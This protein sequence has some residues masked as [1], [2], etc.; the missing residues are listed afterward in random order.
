MDPATQTPDL[1][2]AGLPPEQG[3]DSLMQALQAVSGSVPTE[4]I[5]QLM[6][7]PSLGQRIAQAAAGGVAFMRGQPNPVTPILQQQQEQNI[8]ILNILQKMQ[9][10]QDLN[11][12]R[13]DEMRHRRALE[14]QNKAVLEN[15]KLNQQRQANL[16][17]FNVLKGLMDDAR[18]PPSARANLQPQFAAALSKTSGI[19]IDQIPTTLTQPDIKQDQKLGVWR[20][21]ADGLPPETILKNNPW[22]A[23]EDLPKYA[24]TANNDTVRKQL[25]MP[26]AA[27]QKEQDLKIKGLEADLLE[28]QYPEL[29]LDPKTGAAVLMKV[30]SLYPDQTYKDLTPQQQSV[31]YKSVILEQ[32]QSVIDQ[33]VAKERARASVEMAFLPQKLAL[34]KAAGIEAKLNTPIAESTAMYVDKTGNPAPSNL[35][36]GEAI[37][38]GFFKITPKEYDALNTGQQAMLILENMKHTVEEMKKEHLFVERAG[39]GGL[40][41]AGRIGVQKQMGDPEGSK[42]L[43][44]N[45]ES[46]KAQ[47]VILLRLLG[48]KGVRALGAMTPAMDALNPARGAPATESVLSNIESEI[49][50]LGQNTRTPDAFSGTPTVF[51]RFPKK[52]I[53]SDGPLKAPSME[54][55]IERI[56]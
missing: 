20:D 42:R 35:T 33:E 56:D 54:W 3:N 15:T 8:G 45:F 39:L 40:L 1:Q 24:A 36:E 25:G 49:R 5:A 21:L 55:K 7:P 44:T 30:R 47:M 23:P 17:Q 31:A 11:V 26:T 29:R 51:P 22:L 38:K 4:A 2:S 16:T 27:E 52:D 12:Y 50:V 41:Q 37:R 28:K 48:E 32:R 18:T 14:E 19:P 9:D 6:A 43:L 53:P 10:R 13:T 46:Q 34:Q